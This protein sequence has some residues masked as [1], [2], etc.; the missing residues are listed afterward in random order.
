MTSV[1]GIYL[2]REIKMI[3]FESLFKQLVFLAGG[4]VTKIGLSLKPNRHNQVKFNL[5]PDAHSMTLQFANPL[6][7]ILINIT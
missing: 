5:I 2:D 3:I 6:W 1:P 4:A 7:C